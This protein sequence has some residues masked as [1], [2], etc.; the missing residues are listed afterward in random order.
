MASRTVYAAPE[1]PLIQV[2]EQSE[3]LAELLQ[4]CYPL[5][6]TT[7]AY[8]SPEGLSDP[9]TMRVMRAAVRCGLS[10]VVGKYKEQWRHHATVHP[11][12]LYCIACELGWPEEARLAAG[13]LATRPAQALEELEVESLSAGQYFRLLKFVHHCQQETF[14]I[15]EKKM[16]FNHADWKKMFL[17]VVQWSFTGSSKQADMDGKL[18]SFLTNKEWNIWRSDYPRLAVAYHSSQSRIKEAIAKV[19]LRLSPVSIR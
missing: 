15:I 5:S 19:C 8:W 14:A 6:A 1:L 10:S 17:A 4:L 2:E 13:H 7:S 18:T 12:R 3:V 11:A 9:L 16:T